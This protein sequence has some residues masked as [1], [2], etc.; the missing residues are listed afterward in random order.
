MLSAVRNDDDDAVTQV[1]E[2]LPALEA[3]DDDAPMGGISYWDGVR[4]RLLVEP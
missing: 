3:L 4:I 2:R 1:L